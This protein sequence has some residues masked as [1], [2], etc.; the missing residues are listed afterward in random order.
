MMPVVLIWAFPAMIA[1]GVT[2]HYLIAV[3]KFVEAVLALAMPTDI[4]L[5][6]RLKFT[7]IQ[8]GKTAQTL[9]DK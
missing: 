8:G 4:P 1:V 7:V 3:A 2:G 5:D 6:R 9:R